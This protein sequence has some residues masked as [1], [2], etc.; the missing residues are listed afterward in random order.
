MGFLTRLTFL[1]AG[2]VAIGF[3]LWLSLWLFIVL[4]FVGS[5]AVAIVALRNFL[6]QKDI[7]NPRPGIPPEEQGKVIEGDFERIE[8][9]TKE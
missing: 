4:F 3:V 5:A 2:A 9:D 7:L 6:L 8:P 1:A